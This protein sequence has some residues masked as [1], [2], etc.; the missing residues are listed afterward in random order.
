[1][2]EPFIIN[3][4]IANISPSRNDISAKCYFIVSEWCWHFI[5]SG[6]SRD[7][8]EPPPASRSSSRLAQRPL[9]SLP[10]GRK[11]IRRVVAGQA[12]K[13]SGG[14]FDGPFHPG[15]GTD[16]HILL[17]APAHWQEWMPASGRT[18][19]RRRI[20]RWR[21]EMVDIERKRRLTTSQVLE[22]ESRNHTGPGNPEVGTHIPGRPLSPLKEKRVLV[23]RKG[24]CVAVRQVTNK[25]HA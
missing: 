4:G 2:Q 19:P 14:D 7:N 23:E 11:Q 16:V 13:S 3:K 5:S 20:H 21:L 9:T 22:R 12:L 10:A 17:S 8:T 1:M 25:S 24:E 18:C 15:S 6:Q